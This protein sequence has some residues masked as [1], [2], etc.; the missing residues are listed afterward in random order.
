MAI[1]SRATILHLHTLVP[2]VEVKGAIFWLNNTM[3]YWQATKIKL[4]RVCVCVN[5]QY[6]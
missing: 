6:N 5:S 4:F 2:T 1:Y 3:A